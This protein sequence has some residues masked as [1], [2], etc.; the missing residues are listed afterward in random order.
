MIIGSHSGEL[1]SLD[2]ETGS[3]RWHRPLPDRLEATAAANQSGTVIAIGVV[4]MSYG[5]YTV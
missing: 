3:L 2:I 1:A 4:M 5:R